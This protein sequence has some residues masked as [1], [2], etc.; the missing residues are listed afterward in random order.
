M[1]GNATRS[2]ANQSFFVYVKDV[3]TGMIKRIAIPSDVQIGLPGAPAELQ[4]L[5]RLSINASTFTVDTSNKGLI[6]VS[7]D[8]TVI[9]L[10]L[11]TTPLSG[12]I[13]VNLP[14]T[15]RDG[16]LHFIK[17]MSGTASSVPIDIVPT[18]SV[19]IDG[20]TIK[21]LSDDY[22]SLALIWLGG[23]WR[24]LV[25]GLGASG[26]G[27][28]SND[29]SFVTINPEPTLSNERRLVGSDNIPMTDGGPSST[30]NFDL[31]Q[32]LGT[33]AGTFSYPT[34]TVDQ[35][36][37]ITAISD[38]V[39]PSFGSNPWVDTGSGATYTTSSA[40][41]TGS[42]TVS[43]DGAFGGSLNVAGGISGSITKL[44]DGA[45]PYITAVG[46]ITIMTTSQGQLVLSGGGDSKAST[47]YF[48]DAQG[49]FVLMQ[50]TSSLTQARRLTPGT[51]ITIIDQ[52]AFNNVLVGFDNKVIATLTGSKFSGPITNSLGI[53]AQGV[54][55]GKGFSGS[56]QTLSDGT[57]RY[58][59]GIGG[60]TV[61]TQSNGQVV[62]SS[63][64]TN[65]GGSVV[66]N[67][68]WTD[69]GN[70]VFTTSSVSVDA[71]GRTADQL[72]AD[73][74]FYVSGTQ[75]LAP[76]SSGRKVTLFGGDAYVSGSMI[77]SGTISGSL[78][79]LSDGKTSYIVGIGG[80]NVFTQSNGQVVISGSG[81]SGGA[82]A[83]V[84]VQSQGSGLPFSPYATLN[85]TGSGVTAVDNGSGGVD[86]IVQST[87]DAAG[88]FILASATGSLPQGRVL[89]VG[90]GL[91][92]T[93]G[94]AGGL[95]TIGLTGLSSQSANVYQG[96]CTGALTW[97]NFANWTDLITTI[98][99]NFFDA[100]SNGIVRSG[101]T[102]TVN[103]TGY[104]YVHAFFNSVQSATYINLRL[105]G[106]NGTL[107]ERSTWQ[108]SGQPPSILD[109]V[110]QLSS[111][112]SFKLQFCGN[113]SNWG[114]VDPIGG[115]ASDTMNQRTGDV[116]I[117]RIADPVTI[118]NVP[119][120][121]PFGWQT[122]IDLD[123]TVQAAQTFTGNSTVTI[124]GYKFTQFN[125]GN[126]S[127]AQVIPGTGVQ[128][129]NSA[130]DDIWGATFTCPSLA[131][132]IQTVFQNYSLSDHDIRIWFWVNPDSVSIKYDGAAFGI[133]KTGDGASENIT[134]K[135]GFFDAGLGFNPQVNTNG[136]NYLNLHFADV[137]YAQHNVMMVEYRRGGRQFSFW[138]GSGS[139]GMW[140]SLSTMQ[141]LGVGDAY[142]LASFSRYPITGS[143]DV[144][145]FF[146]LGS[147]GGRAIVESFRRLRVDYLE[148]NAGTILSNNVT[149][150]GTYIAPDSYDVIWWPMHESQGP[151]A[152]NYGTLSPQTKSHLTASNN[153]VRFGSPG[154]LRTSIGNP[155]SQAN[156]LVTANGIAPA[157][158]SNSGSFTVSAWC[159]PTTFNNLN[160]KII[161]KS[162]YAAQ[163]T[164]DAP[165]EAVAIYTPN[166][167]TGE[168][169]FTVTT[170]SAG[171]YNLV[172]NNSQSLGLNMW[173][174]VGLSFDAPHG[175]MSCY[176]N[177][178]LIG[179]VSI[180]NA[181]DHADISQNGW[182]A[183][184]N[185]AIPYSEYFPGYVEDIRV[186]NTVRSADWF[187]KVWLSGRPDANVPINLSLYITGS[188][189]DGGGMG[190]D[191]DWIDGGT[192]IRTTSSVAIS[193]DAKYAADYGTDI[194]FYVS[195]S[196]AASG[197]SGMK[198]VFGGDV[199]I[200]GNLY[201]PGTLTAS[202]TQ[203]SP[204][205]ALITGV[206]GTNVS[207]GSNGQIIISSSIGGSGTFTG[208][209]NMSITG[210]ALSRRHR[211]PL[212]SA[213]VTSPQF[214]A[215]KAN[216]GINYYDPTK[217][218]TSIGQ[219]RYFFRGLFAPVFGNGNAYI[220]LYDYDGII[221][222]VPGPVSGSVLTSSA[223]STL[224]KQEVELTNI[225]QN[226]TGSG[227]LMARGWSDP[228]GSNYINVGGVEFDLEWS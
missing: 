37:R 171:G 27:S 14:V 33:G 4:L 45:T 101:S 174:H 81:M 140:P 54:G 32:I 181:N 53:V 98:P 44:S 185:V 120:T 10:A 188:G 103:A 99:S 189:G 66:F 47:A 92:L 65:T 194:F 204:G 64:L 139:S 168:I 221:T 73:V 5:G 84:N 136:T 211:I 206:G 186:A 25:A 108:Q 16:Q 201:I 70:K 1:A 48:A 187:S 190:Q 220:D 159:F 162:Y 111:G 121:A 97:G 30:V 183:V 39:V 17:D 175:V 62:I 176:L 172:T 3:N 91:S 205:I 57:T 9:A 11:V 59:V 34:V 26:G 83:G 167:S 134:N 216:L 203:V 129:T 61:F 164:W 184:G 157:F 55:P 142:N 195:G 149:V 109:G 18:D 41:I 160:C 7:N 130:N 213:M 200:S 74:H 107:L 137:A 116:T 52:G 20:M 93:D 135:K 2:E 210:S 223:P 96:Y 119:S 147:T 209:F 146:G 199:V 166:N 214:S 173:N 23:Q 161:H 158:P 212:L 78:Q 49:Q 95:L 126:A 28:L 143:G 71:Q 131:I 113:I 6:N 88:Q 218:N 178:Q 179:T 152:Y 222:G 170:G 67:Q 133:M 180:T 68:P 123:F 125:A 79:T 228:S 192:Q 132:P 46:D 106:S 102:F 114:S 150:T 51:G 191:F 89:A 193:T 163:N 38:G 43:K 225:F 80:I 145:L 202:I 196:Q 86:I 19:L 13:K 85:F 112:S 148:N 141:Q 36:G 12:R 60:I 127:N 105:S 128:W 29:I 219:V 198:T 15:P 208:S 122:A 153:T 155:Q 117:I 31:S 87:T 94:G 124:A 75:N 156:Y 169:G 24:M 110:I 100:T 82:T 215:S 165:Y 138:A 224:S 144:S 104:Y 21:T 69:L 217:D 50:L 63:S 58:L 90:S 77:V 22:G 56:L 226:V 118:T 197:S 207:T 40:W 182:W 72:G 115:P 8:D 42:L 35:Y 177:G 76:G 151:I 227:I 154:A